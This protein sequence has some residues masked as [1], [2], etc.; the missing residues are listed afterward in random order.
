MEKSRFFHPWCATFIF[1]TRKF[2]RIVFPI[3]PV[4]ELCMLPMKYITLKFVDREWQKSDESLQWLCICDLPRCFFPDKH[5]QM[6]QFAKK[7][8]QSSG[9]YYPIGCKSFQP[10]ISFW[11]EHREMSSEDQRPS[12]LIYLRT[13]Q[14]KYISMLMCVRVH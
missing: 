10:L 9:R 14:E 7:C 13:F 3:I 6:L 11:L 5:I 1:N 12:A 8:H 4:D 2:P